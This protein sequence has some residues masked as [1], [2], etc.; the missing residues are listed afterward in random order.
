MA[1]VRRPVVSLRSIG[2]GIVAFTRASIMTRNGGYARVTDRAGP[3]DDR[4]PVLLGLRPAALAVVAVLRL[5]RCSRWLSSRSG[6]SATATPTHSCSIEA[7]QAEYVARYGGRDET[8]LDPLMF[9]PP[10]GSFFVG[11]L[12]GTPVASGAWRRSTVE[13]F[14]TARTAEIKRMYVVPAA[15]RAAAW[16]GGCSPTSRPTRPSTAPRRSCWRAACASRRRSSST[17]SSGYTPIPSFGYYKF[18]RLSRCFGRRLPTT[19]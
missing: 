3:G 10:D 2:L 4:W 9:E 6:A 7:V 16:P 14:G 19:T 11:Y 1:A 8:P 13:A 18:A 5:L 15:P 17:T 12:D